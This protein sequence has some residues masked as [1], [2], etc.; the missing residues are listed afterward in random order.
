MGILDRIKQLQA[1]LVSSS[2]ASEAAGWFDD[3]RLIESDLDFDKRTTA[4][5][6]E[7]F[8]QAHRRLSAAMPALRLGQQ[9]SL[10]AA[11][12]A[13][14]ALQSSIECRTT[15]PDGLPLRRR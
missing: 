6:R 5:E 9:P 11:R 15:G 13:L 1:V 12:V 8:H 3:L 2:E 7:L 10:H 4:H 14:S